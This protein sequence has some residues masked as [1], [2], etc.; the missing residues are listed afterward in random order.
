LSGLAF[1]PFPGI[2]Y[3]PQL[4]TRLFGSRN[5]RLLRTYQRPV[6]EA[7]AFEPAIQ[8]LSDA[9]LAAK[10][11]EFRARLKK[12]ESLDD[13]LPEAFAVVREAA[14]RTLKMRHFDMQL[15]GGIA[16]HQG[17]IAEMRSATRNGWDPCSASSA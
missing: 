15:V 4:L 7:T 17:K 16:L 12:G 10:T 9:E 3:V 13:L 6:R 14:Q 5:E 1:S 8:A 2:V 11:E